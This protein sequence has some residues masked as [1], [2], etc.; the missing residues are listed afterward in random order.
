MSKTD[1]VW[2]CFVALCLSI[3]VLGGSYLK[4]D[5]LLPICHSLAP[6]LFPPIVVALPT[7]AGVFDS[8]LMHAGKSWQMTFIGPEC[9]GDCRA[10][11]ALAEAAAEATDRPHLIISA[12]PT[13]LTGSA[14]VGVRLATV[15]VAES[16]GLEAALWT[17]PGYAAT[18]ALNEQHHIEKRWV[19][20]TQSFD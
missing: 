7:S 18:W 12:E 1:A 11:L 19:N 5:E 3:G 9:E 13:D 10:H 17:T 8:T 6:N 15:Q 14:V 2:L 16:V 4:K 20:E